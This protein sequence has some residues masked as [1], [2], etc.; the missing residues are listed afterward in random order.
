M[1]FILFL[2]QIC[3]QTYITQM[4][5][6]AHVAQWARWLDYLTTHTS[7]SPIWRGLAPGFVIHKKGC[8]RLAA[9]VI[10][11]ISCL[12]MVGGSLRVLRRLPPLKLVAMTYWN[13]AESDV[14]HNK[15][16]QMCPTVLFI[17]LYYECVCIG[18]KL[19]LVLFN[20]EHSFQ[21]FEFER[22]L[23]SLFYLPKSFCTN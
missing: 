4:C 1:Y 8:T 6:R 22:N 16:N 20:N 19:N 2:L 3:K 10:K 23:C 15:S 7:L 13:I 9:Q 21:S 14:K 12:P 11:C 5:P 18:S 17:V